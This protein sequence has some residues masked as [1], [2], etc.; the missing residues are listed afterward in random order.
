LRAQNTTTLKG[1]WERV[2]TL[3]DRIEMPDEDRDGFQSQNTGVS[4]RAIQSVSIMI[5]NFTC[6]ISYW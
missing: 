2:R 4:Q 5:V 6:H 3:W 1:L